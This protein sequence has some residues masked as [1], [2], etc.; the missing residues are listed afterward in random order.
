MGG[1]YMHHTVPGGTLA[2]ALAAL[3]QRWR[4]DKITDQPV[5]EEH[6]DLIEH[7]PDLFEKDAVQVWA[8]PVK[9]VAVDWM[10]GWTEQ[11]PPAGVD[12]DDK[13]GPWLAFPLESGGWHIFGRVNT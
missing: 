13:W 4:D 7:W 9:D 3:R 11:H 5:A 12:P 2:D 6:R 8:E 10:R 1:T